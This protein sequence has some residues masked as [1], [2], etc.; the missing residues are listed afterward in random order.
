MVGVVV[1]PTATEERQL[2]APPPM[3]PSTSLLALAL[4]IGGACLV[5]AAIIGGLYATVSHATKSTSSTTIVTSPRAGT[6]SPRAPATPTT[7][8]P[9]LPTGAPALGESV[10]ATPPPGFRPVAPGDGPNGPFDLAGFLQYSENPRADRIAF[11]QNGFVAGYA[12]S[13]SRPTTLGDSRILASVFEFSTP[14]GAEAIEAYES[15]RTVRDE[16][17]VPFPL[18]GASALRFTHRSPSGTIYGYAVTIR[19][20]GDK[21]LYY[22]TAL[23]PA[24]YPPDD[25]VELARRQQRLLRE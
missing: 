2:D 21:R 13:W 7:V 20:P 24:A 12:H 17:G 5:G 6:T 25:I 10:V 16:D 3:S 18:A 22:L 14:E 19:R 23:Y 1:A 4:A 15:G 9:T 8:S 11:E